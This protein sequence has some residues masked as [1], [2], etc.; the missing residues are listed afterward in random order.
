M[1]QR[2][3]NEIWTISSLGHIWIQSG[4]PQLKLRYRICVLWLWNVFMV[5]LAL[6]VAKKKKKNQLGLLPLV[7]FPLLKSEQASRMNYSLL[8]L[9]CLFGSGLRHI[10][11]KTWRKLSYIESMD[12][13]LSIIH[14]YEL[15]PFRNLSVWGMKRRGWWGENTFLFKLLMEQ[16]LILITNI[17]L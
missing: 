9:S 5:C 17:N 6:I 14:S 10:R 8:P 1:L 4:T 7:Y 15:T 13:W 3:G 11:K 12:K 2:D 16:S